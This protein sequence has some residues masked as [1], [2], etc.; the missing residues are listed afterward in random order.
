VNV[1]LDGEFAFGLARI[2]AAWLQVGQELDDQKI[3]ALQAEDAHEVAYQ[4]VLKLLGYRSRSTH[5]VRKNLRDHNVPEEVIAGVLERLRRSR[6]VD[7]E[8]F[9]Q[10][11][12]E[13][14]SEYR[15]RSRRALAMELRQKGITDEV[16]KQ[17][18]EEAAREDEDLAY[19]AALK[20]SRKLKEMEW[21]EFRQKLSGFLAR[22]GFSY[23]VVA[24]V[25]KR[26]WVEQRP[27]RLPGSNLE[28]EE[29]FA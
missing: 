25:V 5:E 10:A 20:Q 6:L 29:G 2:V 22:R 8:R 23:E 18:L 28:N 21:P 19:Q 11:W 24:P 7:D 26:V 1:Y 13:N 3:A 17:T 14:R 4:R 9:A 15:P 16:I 27:G 12:I